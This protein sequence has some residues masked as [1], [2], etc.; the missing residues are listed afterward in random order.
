ML[1]LASDSDSYKAVPIAS[2][3]KDYDAVRRAIAYLSEN[4]LEQPDLDDLA[5]HIGLSA[6]HCQKLFKRWCG[7]S[8]K[9]FLQAITIDNARS[10]L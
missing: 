8:P 5:D 3:A 10:L 1:N 7:L 4:W 9:E 2:G 6:A